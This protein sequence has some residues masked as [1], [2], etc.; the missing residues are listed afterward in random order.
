MDEAH[1]NFNRTASRSVAAGGGCFSAGGLKFSVLSCQYNELSPGL[2]VPE[3]EHPYYCLSFVER[4][5]MRTSCDGVTV[6]NRAGKRT[7]FFMPPAVSHACRFGEEETHWNLSVNFQSAR[8]GGE[9]TDCPPCGSARLRDSAFRG[10][11]VF[12]AGNPPSGDVGDAAVDG[13]VEPSA[14][15]VA[16]RGD[17]AE[18]PRSVGRDFRA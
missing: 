5:S 17:A 2:R 11:G 14:G 10:D 12:A 1:E 9:R 13:A 18:F 8:A 16:E 4:S 7:L 3:H 6:E 15:G